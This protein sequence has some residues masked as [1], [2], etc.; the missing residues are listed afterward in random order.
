VERVSGVVGGS[1]FVRLTLIDPSATRPGLE[2]ALL[3]AAREQAKERSRAGRMVD[4][5]LTRLSGEDA[6]GLRLVVRTLDIDGSEP[7]VRAAGYC[8]AEAAAAGIAK[9]EGRMRPRP[10]ITNQAAVDELQP[11]LAESRAARRA[12]RER[13]EELDNCVLADC[14]QGLY[15]SHHTPD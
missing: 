2:G 8:L 11:R 4:R 5:V 15:W 14:L 9:T 12:H 3:D 13:E 7:W 6:R 10:V 1:S